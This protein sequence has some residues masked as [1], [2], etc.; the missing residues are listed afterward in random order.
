M[1]RSRILT[2]RTRRN[3]AKY[4][5]D[6]DLG[7]RDIACSDII[8]KEFEI[9]GPFVGKDTTKFIGATQVASCILGNERNSQQ[10]LNKHDYEE[11]KKCTWNSNS[12]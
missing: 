3:Q 9:D 11:E 10:E 7:I 8:R 12:L 6:K 1:K 5:I 4:R 2:C